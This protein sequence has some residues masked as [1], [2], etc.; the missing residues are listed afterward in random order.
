VTL[1]ET[2]VLTVERVS[3]TIGAEVSGV[4]LRETL[5]DATI[6]A[7]RAALLEHKVLFFR[8]QPLTQLEHLSFGRRFGDLEVHPVTPADQ[9]HAEIF[10]LRHDAEH[11]GT[12]NFWHSDV[13]WRPEP[14][15]GSIL[16][17]RVL[18]DVGG[19]TLFAD[20]HGAYDSLSDAMK[21]RIEGLIALHDFTRVFGLFAT[22]ERRAEMR[23]EHPPQEHPVVR[24]HPE[25][26]RKGIYVNVAFTER[27]V[28]MG[29]DDSRRLLRHLYRQ[30]SIPELQCRLRWRP[31]TIAFWDNRATQHYAVSDY[32]PNVRVMERVT[33]AGDRPC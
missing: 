16:R 4:D 18:P 22:E 30:A 12:E 33:V 24:T 10:V 3:P 11:K 15:M 13:T 27:I 17:A 28:G 20:M 9:E 21:E 6:A 26:G 23:E 19:D 7:L 1:A 29:D 25:T 5:P 31:D 2:P 14:S 8:D 32:W